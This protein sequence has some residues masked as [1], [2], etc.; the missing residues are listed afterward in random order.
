M[1]GYSKKIYG[2][3]FAIALAVFTLAGGVKPARILANPSDYQNINTNHILSDAKSTI[4]Q[5]SS[6]EFTLPPLPYEYDALSAYIDRATMTIH[7]DKHHAGYVENLNE[8]IAL[9]PELEGKSVE[10]LLTGLDTVPE[11]IR[12]TIRNN[13]G[14]HANHTMFWSIMTPNSPAEPQGEIAEAIATTFGDFATFQDE[15][16]TA[17]KNQFGS[18]WAWLVLNRDGSLEVT[19]TANQDSPLINDQYPVMG[20]DVWEHAYYLKYQNKR[21]DYLDAWW[22]VVNWDEV[23]NR[24][25]AAQSFFS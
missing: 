11:D 1:F 23:N 3:I 10:E 17:G 22:N 4:A 20:N 6:P 7:H 19:S 5:A 24:Y 13:G 18:G 25:Q 12:T 14:G 8:A 15:F 21:A 16:N 2:F 9:H